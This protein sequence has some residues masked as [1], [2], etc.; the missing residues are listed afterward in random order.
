VP[1]S[2]TRVTSLLIACVG[3]LGRF[4]SRYLFL[5]MGMGM[6]MGM[7]GDGFSDMI[8]PLKLGISLAIDYLR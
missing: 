6:G 5:G 2:A 3:T 4:A 7:G 1:D 8:N